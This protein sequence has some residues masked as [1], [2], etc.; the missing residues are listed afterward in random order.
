MASYLGHLS[1]AAP[2]G[3]AYGIGAAYYLFPG[4][5]WGVILLGAGVTTLGGMI[6]DLDS[7]SG[8]P[9]REMFGLA[10]AAAPILLFRRFEMMGFTIEQTLV[11]LAALYLLIRYGLAS[12]FKQWTVHRGMF[13]SIPAMLI[14]GLLVF[15]VNHSP[16]IGV[17]LYLAGGMMLGFLSHLI[18][19]EIYAVDF[20]GLKI[21]FNKFA[22]SAVKL[23]S[24]SKPAT[25]AA[26]TILVVLGVLA[27]LDFT[28]QPS[29]GGQTLTVAP[30]P[31]DVG[32]SE[33]K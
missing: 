20:M 3:A 25:A 13:H 22:G 7:D 8:I 16:A 32:E 23:W 19:D 17:R 28:G 24:P 31:A 29:L 26:Y 4:A 33:E 2:L 10:A 27:W 1:L 14:A 18:L 9:V 30:R 15:L 21:K 5:D 12:L 11:I 6:P